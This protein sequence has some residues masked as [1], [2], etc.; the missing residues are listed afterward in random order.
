M[1]SRSSV[2]VSR[3]RA[4]QAFTLMEILVVI[5][6]ILVLA[7]IAFPVFTAIQNKARKAVALNNMKQLTT[8]LITFAG[9]N[10][11]NLPPEDSKGT[12]TWQAAADPENG[13]VWYNSLPRMLGHKG[14]GDY[15]NTPRDFY[16]KDNLLFLPGASYPETDKKLGRPLFAIAINTKLQRR[17]DAGN[18]G[19]KLTQITQPARTVIFL[20]QG[21]KGEPKASP[22]QPAYDGT[23]KGSARSFVARYGGQGVLAFLD[24]HSE[25]VEAKDV[26]TETGRIIWTAGQVPDIIWCRTPEEDPNK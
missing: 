26:L 4:A 16:S 14:V 13:K 21:I 9:Q 5:A 1:T 18:K 15:A 24:G 23:P 7:A 25:S 2:P 20:E 12:D 17:D 22:T 11:Q 10:D 19:A 3:H 8:T 6:I